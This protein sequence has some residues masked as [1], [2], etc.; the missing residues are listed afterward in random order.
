LI[1]GYSFAWAAG[2]Y[3]WIRLE[4]DVYAVSYVP[5][6]LRAGDALWITAAVLLISFL[7]TLYPAR[8]AS[9]VA[10]AEGLRYE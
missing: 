6:E 8:R 9:S 4:A 2:R 3:R 7:S 10:P 5:F 1:L